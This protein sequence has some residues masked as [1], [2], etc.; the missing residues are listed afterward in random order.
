M[1]VA[2]ICGLSCCGPDQS[3]SSYGQY[4]NRA[5]LPRSTNDVLHRTLANQML[6]RL[7]WPKVILPIAGPTV[8]LW[9]V[10][11]LALRNGTWAISKETKWGIQ[12]WQG[13]EI[14]EAVFFFVTNTL[15]VFGL[16]AFDNGKAIIDVFDDI[17]P[18]VSIAPSPTQLVQA[19][20]L[21]PA[22]YDAARLDGLRDSLILLRKKSRSFYLASSVFEGRLRI[23]L[24]CL[25]AYCRLADDLVDNATSIEEARKWIDRL[26]SF[27]DLK[28]R[29]GIVGVNTK[30][31]LSDLLDQFPKSARMILLQLPTSRVSQ[32]P[33]RH[34]L[35]GFKTDL[36]FSEDGRKFPI[37]SV[38]DLSTYAYCVAS[39]VAILCLDLVYFYHAQPTSLAAKESC[40]SSAIAMGKALQYINIARDVAVDAKDGRCYLPT[41]LLQTFDVAP[42]SVIEHRGS[43]AGAQEARRIILEEAIRLYRANVDAI[44]DLPHQARGGIRVAVE[45]YVEIGRVMM[46]NG[47]TR[48]DEHEGRMRKASVPKW[49]RIAV[50]WLGMAGVGRGRT[51]K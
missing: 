48:I 29:D 34:L 47:F 25:Y 27:L 9:I 6:I 46:R 40:I 21:S 38:D 39:T 26:S 5:G 49:R 23:D 1:S 32:E 2:G 42:A 7:P 13:M 12:P 24:I 22:H 11:T 35:D 20:L 8:Y 33:L 41:E 36:E 16:V 19:Q 51:R 3:Y 10:D 31:E 45:A 43:Q 50:A 30:T 17:F 18:Y 44:E 4:H 28:Y 15:V 14:E 37:Q